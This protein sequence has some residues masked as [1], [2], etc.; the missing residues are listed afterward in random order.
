MPEVAALCFEERLGLLVDRDITAREDRRL[1]TRCHKATLRQTACI[2]DSAYR[3]PRGWA[4][5]LRL[6]LAACQ[7]GRDRH[8][9]RLTGPTG[10]GQPWLA[11]AWGHPACREGWTGLSL[12]R[13]RLLQECPLAKG[14]G[15]SVTL[16]T[17]LAK[18]A[19]LRLDAWGLA[20][21]RDDTRRDLVEL[22]D[23]RHDCRA[24]LVPRQFPGAPWHEAMGE[25]PLAEAILDRRV[26]NASQIAFQGDS[27]RK[28]QARLPTAPATYSRHAPQRVAPSD[29]RAAALPGCPGARRMR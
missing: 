9:G 8:N 1:Q 26:H 4:K 2:T 18:T 6:S 15:R 17:A 12:R 28:R 27:M 24:T 7:W 29:Q 5:A 16:M 14:D 23:D 11:C 19:V 22:L 20:P 21:L 25:P 10:I 13:P 3:P